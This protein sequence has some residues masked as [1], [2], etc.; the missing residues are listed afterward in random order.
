MKR[1][2]RKMRRGSRFFVKLREKFHKE[3]LRSRFKF[4]HIPRN[5]RWS[6]RLR[7]RIYFPYEY[8][9]SKSFIFTDSILLKINEKLEM[10]KEYEN[11]QD[12]AKDSD[13]HVSHDGILR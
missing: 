13:Y 5:S 4:Y 1:G 6:S 11:Q 10:G 3:E 9:N 8:K 12:E 7:L 2:K